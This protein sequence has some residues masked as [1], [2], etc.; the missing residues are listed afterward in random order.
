MVR[1]GFRRVEGRWGY[2][3]PPPPPQTQSK[4]P[5]AAL[6]Y[7]GLGESQLVNTVGLASL[8]HSAAA[9]V[10]NFPQDFDS[11][12]RPNNDIGV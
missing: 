10:I 11:S 2:I 8:A 5:S 9:T 6:K 7:W 1:Y 12:N 3:N 4:G